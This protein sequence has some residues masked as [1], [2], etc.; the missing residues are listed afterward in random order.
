MALRQRVR[1]HLQITAL[2]RT[3]GLEAALGLLWLAVGGAMFFLGKRIGSGAIRGTRKAT[4]E[5]RGERNA[6]SAAMEEVRQRKQPDQ[7]LRE[8]SAVLA[9]VNLASHTFLESGDWSAASQHLLAFASRQTQSELGLLAVV[10][11]GP[12]LRVLAQQEM[13]WDRN[14]NGARYES[15][16]KQLEENRYFEIEHPESLLGEVLHRGETVFSND[17]PHDPR[18]KGLPEG[19]PRLQNFLGVPIFKGPE[20]VA[21][22]G[23]ANRPGGYTGEEAQSLETMCQMT[24]VL[25]DN[26]RQSMT[27]K[28]LEQE[29]ARLESEFRQHK[30]WKCWDSLRG[31]WR[32]ISTTC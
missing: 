7:E 27:R 17:P 23:V 21:L 18:S 29:R 14:Q 8:M 6:A 9:A 32:T 1:F 28:Q 22:I 2:F 16:M 30:K 11:E 31:E 4:N 5:E 26:Y 10:L 24:G 15:K 3:N 13:A 12:V 20:I 19:H 25:Y